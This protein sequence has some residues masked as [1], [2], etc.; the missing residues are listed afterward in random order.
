MTVV[1]LA[2]CV[3]GGTGRSL[4]RSF[5]P[6]PAW[7]YGAAVA[8]PVLTLAIAFGVIE[9]MHRA[10]GMEKVGYAAPFLAQGYGAWVVFVLVAVQPAVVE[11][12]AFRGVV[13]TS[14]VPTLSEV[15]AVFVSA[16]LFM[17]LHL[18]PAAFPHTFAMGVVAGFVRLR[19]GS[20]LPCVL[21]HFVH[22]AAVVGSEVYLGF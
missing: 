18:G 6:G 19:T 3:A 10:L 5:R 1:V 13:L 9:T 12:L 14:L 20:L 2:W 7:G 16:L 4:V 17:T 11:E 22:N 21:M 15:E 8:S